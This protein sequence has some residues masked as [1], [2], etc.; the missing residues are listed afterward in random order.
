MRRVGCVLLLSALPVSLAA[1]AADPFTGTWRLNVRKSRYSRGDCPR[2][3]II[4]METAGNGV[5]YR[6]ETVL[7]GGERAGRATPRITA[8]PRPWWSRR[9]G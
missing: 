7:A 3:M 6:S 4:E 8:A 5:R 2:S 9:G 1:Q